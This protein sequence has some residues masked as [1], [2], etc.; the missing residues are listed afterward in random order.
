MSQKKYKHPVDRFVARLPGGSMNV[1][2]FVT[3]MAICG[4]VGV[5]IFMN[6]DKRKQGHDLFSQERPEA[7]IRG[8]E[9]LREQFLKERDARREERRKAE[10]K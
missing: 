6:S 4:M 1:K 10:E 9:K 3:A 5:P 2:A 7:I 8:Q